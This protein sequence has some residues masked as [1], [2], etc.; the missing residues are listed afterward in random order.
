MHGVHN[1]YNKRVAQRSSVGGRAGGVAAAGGV[2]VAE[3]DVGV[4]A[5]RRR[6]VLTQ[7][8]I[9]WQPGALR[10]PRSTPIRWL[11]RVTVRARALAAAAATA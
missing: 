3:R 5:A 9:W 10:R 6:R 2:D 7:H 11:R 4:R 8:Y 1:V